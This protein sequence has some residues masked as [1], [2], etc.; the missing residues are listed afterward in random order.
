MFAQLLAMLLVGHCAGDWW[1][2]TSKMA[3][4]KSN[5]NKML[6]FHSLIYSLCIALFGFIVVE[7]IFATII[8]FIVNLIFHL[9]LDK[10]SFLMWYLGFIKNEEKPPQWLVFVLDQTFHFTV[11]VFLAKIITEF[12]GG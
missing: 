3:I 11:L 5:N 12:L 1:F 10:R 9:I 2:Q 8:L 4:K 6:L 7:S